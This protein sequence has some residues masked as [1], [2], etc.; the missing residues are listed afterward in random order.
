[1]RTSSIM[2]TTPSEALTSHW[3]VS[4]VDRF[5]RRQTDAESAHPSNNGGARMSDKALRIIG[6][7]IGPG[8]DQCAPDFRS[9][10]ATLLNKEG[11]R[12]Q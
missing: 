5:A 11:V 1:M 12:Q 2:P 8:R 9:T 4:A 3:T 6:C 7:D 10:A